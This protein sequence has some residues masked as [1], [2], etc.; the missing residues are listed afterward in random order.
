MNDQLEYFRTLASRKLSL[1]RFQ[2]TLGVKD[3]AVE[4]APKF[5]VKEG[6]ASLAA[7][8]HDLARE[9]TYLEQLKKAR[10][11]N[12]ILYQE[13]LKIPQVIHGRIAAYMLQNLYGIN[14]EDVLNAVANHTLGRPGMS[15]LEMLIYSADLA[16]PGRD[17]PGV[18]KLRQ[19]LYH[20]LKTGTL[21]CIEHTL[22][23]LKKNNKPIHPLT[24]L[25]YEDLKNGKASKGG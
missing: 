3:L 23:Y 25:A 15:P 16:E 17:F 5:G 4:L 10:E 20:D 7:L 13:D 18:D 22:Y 9:Y 6:D 24:I 14:N 21:A 12:L 19:K 1:K 2:H 8:T 11:W